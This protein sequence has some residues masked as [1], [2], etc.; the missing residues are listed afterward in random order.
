MYRGYQKIGLILGPVAFVGV[1]A[2]P[3]IEGLSLSAQHVAAVTALMVVWWIFEAVPFAATAL[4]PLALFP[5]LGIISA[6]SVSQAYGDPNIFLFAGGFFIA[7]AMQKWNLHERIALQVLKRTGSKPQTL[8]GGFMVATAFLSMWISNTATAL[9][10]LPIALAVVEMVKRNAEGTGLDGFAVC[11]LLGIAYSASIG[12]VATLIGSPPN[13][14]LL[15]QYELFY[16][17]APE[18]GF[19]QWMMIGLPLSVS[20]LAITWYL[21]TRWLFRFEGLSLAGSQAYFDRRLRELG[22]MQRGEKIVLTVWIATALLWIFRDDIDLGGV[23]IPG[24]SSWFP[25]PELLHNGTVAMIGSLILFVTPV[26][27]R[28]GQFALDWDWAQR[29]PWGTLILFGGGLALAKGFSETGLVEWIGTQL[30]VLKGANLLLIVLIVT[31]LLTFVTELT[32]NVATAAIMLPILGGALAPV[33]GVHP[34][35]LMVPATLAVSC[36]FMFPVAT[37][38]NAIVFGSGYLRVP[39]M[40]RAGV[41]INLVSIAFITLLAYFLV[42]SVFDISMP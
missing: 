13:S 21:L 37:P 32:S 22:A 42:G 3:E 2:I 41:L 39:Q 17:E 7:M 11:V 10:M 34:L 30:T 18:I 23:V 4:I 1:M 6:R 25:R 33:L 26:D 15:G 14:V 36:A 12:G 16:P 5:L 35:L 31:L 8:V 38:P 28:R 27:W 9:M 29:I 40:A 19:L 20:L 24:W